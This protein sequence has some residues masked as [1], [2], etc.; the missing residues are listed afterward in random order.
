MV[1]Q[2]QLDRDGAN[3]YSFDFEVSTFA[4]LSAVLSCVVDVDLMVAAS[5]ECLSLYIISFLFLKCKR[6][7]NGISY[8]FMITDFVTLVSGLLNAQGNNHFIILIECSD[9][10]F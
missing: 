5:F 1:V 8:G 3:D 7:V 4:S 6:C 10:L 9:F 2:F